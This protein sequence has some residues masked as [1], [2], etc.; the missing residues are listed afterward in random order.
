[1]DT[2]VF[3]IIRGKGLLNAVV[4]D[5]KRT[6]GWTAWDLCLAMRDRGL[7]VGAIY[8]HKMLLNHQLTLVL[9]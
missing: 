4:I 5:D 8:R 2:D 9:G 7:L 1:M 3:R 6:N